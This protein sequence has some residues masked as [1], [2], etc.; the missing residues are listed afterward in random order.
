MPNIFDKI[1]IF[2]TQT[3][4]KLSVQKR[5]SINPNHNS[6]IVIDADTGE[7]MLKAFK[8]NFTQK[9]NDNSSVEI[10]GVNLSDDDLDT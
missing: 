2:L 9:Q 8:T 7:I 1:R 4:T 10:F 6:K 3:D 5:K